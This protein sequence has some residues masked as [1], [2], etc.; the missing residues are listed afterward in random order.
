MSADISG[1]TKLS[2]RLAG[3]GRIGAEQISDAINRC[4]TSL[5]DVVLQHGG[6]VLF[7]GGDALFIVFR[8]THHV[9]RASVTAVRMQQ[10]VAEVG[11]VETDGGAVRLRMSVGVA[12]GRALLVV[13]EGFR[14]HW[15]LIGP[16]VD[17]ALALEATAVAGET[18]AKLPTG[19]VRLTRSRV[20]SMSEAELSWNPTEPPS[21]NSA[22]VPEGLRS[23]LRSG[24]AP[25]EHRRVVAAFGDIRLVG[26][27]LQDRA[28][29]LLKAMATV[30]SVEDEMG[31]SVYE[32]D[33]SRHGAKI[34]LF[35]GVPVQSDDDELLMLAA[36][37]RMVER[38]PTGRL[39]VGVHSGTAFTADVGHPLRR[40]Y[41]TL[42]DTINTAARLAAAASLGQVLASEAV[43]A[44]SRGRY[45]VAGSLMLALKGKRVPVLAISVGDPVEA[46]VLRADAFFVGREAELATL[47]EALAN[48]RAGRG[49]SVEIVG[50]PGS[51]KTQLLTAF[52]R[53]AGEP[54]ATI[55]GDVYGTT[56]PYR[57]VQ[58]PLRNLVET[59]SPNLPDLSSESTLQSVVPAEL[60]AVLPLIAAVLGVPTSSTPEVAAIDPSR[61]GDLTAYAVGDLIREQAAP[62][63]MIVIEDAHWLDAA[64]RGLLQHLQR[65][66]LESGWL[67]VATRR[68]D[69]P[70]LWEDSEE[71]HL[72][73]LSDAVLEQIAVNAAGERALSD[74]DVSAI[75]RRAAGS[76]LFAAQLAT[77][78]A[79]GASSDSLPVSAERT[80]GARIDRLAPADRRLLRQVSVLGAEPSHALIAQS[81][82]RDL[83]QLRGGWDALAEFVVVNGDG[84][85]FR[86]DLV[87]LV[88]YEGLPHAE[89]LRIHARAGR[90]LSKAAGNA[91]DRQSISAALVGRHL[92][93]GRRDG[94][95][96][97]WLDR[98]YEAA[99][100]LGAAQEAVECARFSV[101]SSA[102]AGRSSR[103]QARTW[104]RLA[105]AQAMAGDQADA[106][107]SFGRA[108]QGRSAVEQARVLALR[109]QVEGRRGQYSL[110]V[111]WANQGLH[112]LD[113]VSGRTSLEVRTRLLIE[114]ASARCFQEKSQESSADAEHALSQARVLDSPVLLAEALLQAYLS[115]TLA[116]RRDAEIAVK[117]AIEILRVE[118]AG[119]LLGASLLD[120]G[121]DQMFR[122]DWPAAL[123]SFA[124][125]EEA[126]SRSGT[127]VGEAITRLNRA[128]IVLE[129]GHLQMAAE[130]NVNCERVLRAAGGPL[131]HLA[132][133][134][135]LRGRARES[136]TVEA[137]KAAQ[138]IA[139]VVDQAR[140][141]LDPRTLLDIQVYQLEALVLA[142][143]SESALDLYRQISPSL[144]ALAPDQVVAVTAAR[145]AG[146]AMAQLGHSEAVSDIEST[147]DRARRSRADIEVARCIDALEEL[148]PGS[149]SLMSLVPER[150]SIR[151]RHG[152]I[153]EPLYLKRR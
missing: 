54:T 100:R 130:M 58:R 43:M 23:L 143:N 69:S 34:L 131:S 37:R 94:A 74:A 10:A 5:I 30:A 106:S 141:S 57:A 33:V 77:Y 102:R 103:Y 44:R 55:F 114:R 146:L 17:S 92:A 67:M 135:L 99:L 89:R 122:G 104:E 123:A 60:S 142:W 38:D 113:G 20:A 148:V 26:R 153:A 29:T 116:H 24:H 147:L 9:Q 59:R 112:L 53:G 126:F 47:N 41:A 25:P 35:T 19:A 12:S 16:G 120:L 4:F 7:F 84:L 45:A 80:I 107:R 134:S 124:E 68:P 42:G 81:V 110:A 98:A 72:E 6:D 138:E 49:A 15:F 108:L 3:H 144:A 14:R 136:G 1:F 137:A 139:D 83:S 46:P 22:F 65:V 105:A 8:G 66:L 145:L 32:T 96:L 128:G 140:G 115:R 48:H 50:A 76:P 71:V 82:D 88:A 21:G 117:E 79:G 40:T 11:R 27:S 101:V 78:V 118:D 61:V 87:R 63:G 97:P 56:L 36:V 62:P 95:A 129:Q 149:G 18:L 121:T 52:L 70:R 150:D 151:A 119:E 125:A 73:P 13:T 132:Q 90:A 111:R 86:H 2:E 127:V 31:V 152:V 28:A 109:S 64:S 51:G 39:A 75:V 93:M 91:E 85:T 133:A